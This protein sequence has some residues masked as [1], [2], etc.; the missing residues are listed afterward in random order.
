[1]FVVASE[2]QSRDLKPLSL[3]DQVADGVFRVLRLFNLRMKER[4]RP[5]DGSLS[6]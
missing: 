2:L 4:Y 5:D 3:L 1:M 6:S